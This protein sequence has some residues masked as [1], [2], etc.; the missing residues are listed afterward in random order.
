MIHFQYNVYTF[1]ESSFSINHT[2]LLSKRN[3]ITSQTDIIR[4]LRATDI[5]RKLCLVI[6]LG[7]FMF[8]LYGAIRNYQ[9]LPTTS[10]V[11]NKYG[12]DGNKNIIYPSM[13][14]CTIPVQNITSQKWHLW[15]GVPQCG[16]KVSPYLGTT[17]L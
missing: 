14:F 15:N 8:W 13:T 11:F 16:N 1:H 3:F 2:S 12:D 10:K 4:M 17:Y 6:F 5:F 7:S 9:S